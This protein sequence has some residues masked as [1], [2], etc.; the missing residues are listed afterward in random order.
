MP[1]STRLV[2]LVHDRLDSVLTDRAA[3]LAQISPDLEPFIGFSRDLL[4]GGKRFRALFCYWGWEAVRTAPTP[5]DP[6][7]EPDDRDLPAIVEMCAALE[8]FHAAAL[9]HDDIM[10]NSDTRRGL[11][12]A[13][14]RFESIHGESRWAGS[15]EG[16]GR[17][18]ALLLGDL[19]LGWSDELLDAG[20]ALLADRT[21]A[22]AT[23]DEFVRM[24][25]EVTLG[26][27]LDILEEAS[28]RSR[29]EA[30]LL[31]RA[32]RVIVYKSAKYSVEAPLALGAAAAG[33]AAEQIEAVR[34]FGL[35]LGVAYQLRD[36]LLGVFGDPEV[37]GKPAGDDLREGKR[38]VLI[39]L[40]R[41]ALPAGARQLLDELLGDPELDG[42]QIEVLQTAIRE[43]GAVDKVE[44]II[45]HNV[46]KAK[47]AL[48]GAP[49][50][51][52]AR[53]QLSRL[54][55]TVTRRSS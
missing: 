21:A 13:H 3:H 19:L 32:H 51:P 54:A 53:A 1:G 27:Y 24:R 41:P 29:P 18:G 39:A 4:A 5:I 7:P 45:A 42:R 36:D 12:A 49:L 16:Y 48:M 31:P 47:S 6:L 38:T 37:T 8:V 20:L 10:D 30:D 22:R 46:D 52:T 2:D 11:P 44:R 55:D 33:A 26:Q 9:V 15:R 23:R 43:S 34:A 35:P 50:G 40:A 28:W 14:R 17:S 25:T